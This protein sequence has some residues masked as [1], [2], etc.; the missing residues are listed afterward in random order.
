MAVI[1][2]TL[3]PVPDC[4]HVSFLPE[5]IARLC[6]LE[7]TRPL[8]EL[9][10]HVKAYHGESLLFTFHDA[11]TTDLLISGEISETAVAGFSNHIDA[12][13]CREPNVN[14]RDPEQLRR[15]LWALENP[16]KVKIAGE[17]WWRRIWRRLT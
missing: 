15:F 16:D 10:D 1:R 8:N 3:F 7:T 9:F 5:V 6:E 14:K 11:F 17:P 4:Y 13:Y 2:D 12:C